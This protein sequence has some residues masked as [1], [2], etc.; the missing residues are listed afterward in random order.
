MNNTQKRRKSK[1]LN[2][3][4][5]EKR[6]TR[7]INKFNGG[8]DVLNP[9]HTTEKPDPVSDPDDILHVEDIYPDKGKNV[10]FQTNQMNQWDVSFNAQIANSINSSPQDLNK[11]YYVSVH[12]MDSEGENPAH[13]VVALYSYKK[14]MNGTFQISK[15]D[16]PDAVA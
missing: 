1:S 6:G 11:S 14:Q 16:I 12:S 9:L 7:K 8:S 3:L 4:L 10:P 13:N 2:K 5:E 15:I